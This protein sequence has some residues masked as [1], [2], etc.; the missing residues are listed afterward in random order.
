MQP[1]KLGIW[2]TLVEG[3]YDSTWIF[4]GHEGFVA[5]QNNIDLTTW[6]LKDYGIHCEEPNARAHGRH[7]V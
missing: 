6:Q 3:K 4:L 7:V 1:S 2:N 5:K